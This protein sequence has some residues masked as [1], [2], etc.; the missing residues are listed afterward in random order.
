MVFIS[1][2]SRLQGYNLYCLKCVLDI[3][4]EFE[5]ILGYRI[6]F[7]SQNTMEMYFAH[8]SRRVD[9]FGVWTAEVCF[10]FCFVP[11]CGHTGS[12]GGSA[13]VNSHLP[14]GQWHSVYRGH[15]PITQRGLVTIVDSH[16]PK[17]RPENLRF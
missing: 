8:D 4:L 10:C 11:L 3:A 2:D 16:C 13:Q 5:G 14:L 1:E 12:L 9:R 6:R 17:V 7:P 15:L